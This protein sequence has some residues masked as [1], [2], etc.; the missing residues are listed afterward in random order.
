[1]KDYVLRAESVQSM[2]EW[3][4]ALLMAGVGGDASLSESLAISNVYDRGGDLK[5]GFLQVCCCCCCCVFYSQVEKPFD[6]L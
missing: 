5:A 6:F 1:L 3:M 4:Q 2:A